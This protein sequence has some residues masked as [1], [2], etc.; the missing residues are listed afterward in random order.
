[1]IAK[2]TIDHYTCNA[3]LKRGDFYSWE[4][5]EKSTLAGWIEITCRA[6]WKVSSFNFCPQCSLEVLELLKKRCNTDHWKS[7]GI[8]ILSDKDCGHRPRGYSEIMAEHVRMADA[9][10]KNADEAQWPADRF[11]GVIEGIGELQ[12]RLLSEVSKAPGITSRQLVEN[13][14]LES[15]VALAGVISGLSKKL[16][17]LD[18]KPKTVFTI[19]VKWT[20]KKKTRLFMLEESFKEAGR[21]C[22]LW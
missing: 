4:A 19:E 12:R 14:G 20:G 9:C 22:G 6:Y 17:Q 10:M 7:L 16:R 2:T 1:M 11:L 15:E 5:E 8:K 3:C 21:S 13:L 18:I